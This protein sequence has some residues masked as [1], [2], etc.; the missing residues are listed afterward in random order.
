MDDK[1]DIGFGFDFIVKVYPVSFVNRSDLEK[2]DKILLPPSILQKISGSELKGPIIFEI[3][4]LNSTR[5][6]HCGVMDFTADEGC[7]YLPRWMMQ[8]LNAKEGEKF[9]FAYTSLEKG[10]YVKLQP[11][12]DDFLNISNP[13]AVLEAK[14]RYFTCLTRSDIIAIDYND[15]IYWIN[16]V[17]VKPGMAILIVDTDI[18][19][20]FVSPIMKKE[21]ELN[22]T[23][24]KN[25]SLE[26]QKKNDQ[27][28]LKP[29]E[30][31]SEDEDKEK[32]QK[33]YGKG[34]IVK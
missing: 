17:E 27:N 10:S 4:N 12:T 14:L 16:V 29:E 25:N 6:S 15:K 34:Q 7:A 5:K 13:K 20:E 18:D 22:G 19:V 8:N 32:D 26:Y 21:G 2:G 30:S 11:Q 24:P 23:I 1:L 3:K 28:K 31:S 9:L 33:F